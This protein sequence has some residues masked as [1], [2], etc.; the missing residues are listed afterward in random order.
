MLTLD[1]RRF[2]DQR[3][4]KDYT[5][6][7]ILNYL[8]GINKILKKSPVSRDLSKF[9]GPAPRTVIRRF[10]SWSKA[11]KLAGLRPQT[12]Q[13]MSGERTF[14]IK[15]W[16]EFESGLLYIKEMYEAIC[17]FQEWKNDWKA[18]RDIF[19]FWQLNKVIC[20]EYLRKYKAE[21]A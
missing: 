9:P 7:D 21:A 16:R 8:R 19:N 13:L 1:V 5:N 6:T 15:N 2:K 12:N 14:I 11:L 4:K 10:G 3:F 20:E 18:A 17:Y